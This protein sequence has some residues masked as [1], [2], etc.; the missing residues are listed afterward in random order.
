MI[1]YDE[2]F[3]LKKIT[4]VLLHH[5]NSVYIKKKIKNILWLSEDNYIIEG[6][7]ISGSFYE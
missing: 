7:Y 3:T 1:V 6:F 2:M 5:I 4:N